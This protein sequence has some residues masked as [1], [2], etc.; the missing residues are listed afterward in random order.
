VLNDEGSSSL[1]MVSSESSSESSDEE[2]SSESSSGGS[3][4]KKVVQKPKVK[5]KPNVPAFSGFGSRSQPPRGFPAPA[6]A[7]TAAV[8]PPKKPFIHLF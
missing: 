5:A 2:Q 4:G 7:S 6:P 1:N 3:E 8:P